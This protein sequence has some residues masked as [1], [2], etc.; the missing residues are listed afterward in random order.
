[1]SA[2]S[3]ARAAAQLAT[4]EAR[5]GAKSI[6]ALFS[7]AVKEFVGDQPFVLAAALSYY[8]LLSM[9]P[10]L[11]LV[12]S[13]A[14]VVY[15]ADAAEG[16]VVDGLSG[17]VGGD[18]AEMIQGA[19]ANAH[20]AG[21][22]WISALLGVI[23]LLV[24]ATTAFAQLQ[25]ALNQ[26]WGVVPPKRALLHA[27][28]ARA[29]SFLFVALLGAAVI[30]LLVASS[31]ISALRA[32]PLLGHLGFAWRLV[33]LALPLVL[34]T[35]LFAALFRWLPDARIRWRDVWI[36]GAMTSAL[37]VVGRF[38][39]GLYIGRAGVGSAY[40]AAGS[41]VVLMV[42]TFYSALIVLFGAQLTQV[43]AAQHGGGV[44]PIRGASLRDPVVAEKTA[45]SG[46]AGDGVS[47][48]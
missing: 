38:A 32:N 13:I 40:G 7:G 37:F 36:G 42:W 45:A 19:L 48:R 39:I 22:S 43:F 23:G 46:D 3:E 34:M 21:T 9:A 5:R 17:M 30:G 35:G 25:N 27:L 31:V 2:R 4:R 18:T 26:I 33:D 41:L 29:L 44:E 28:Q 10:L 16:A 14:G 20:K 12:V 11:L 8:S 1:M 15:G 24:G 6:G 47:E